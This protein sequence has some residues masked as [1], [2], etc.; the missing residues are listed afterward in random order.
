MGVIGFGIAVVI[1]LSGRVLYG[2]NNERIIKR[3]ILHLLQP[4]SEEEEF[5]VFRGDVW[6]KISDQ[7][8]LG[9][10]AFHWIFHPEN[11]V[12]GPS[13]THLR[14]VVWWGFAAKDL[15]TRCLQVDPSKRITV[16]EALDHPWIVVSG[17]H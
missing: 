12:G 17:W 4:E 3:K 13:V 11:C 16:E 2:S 14:C 7:G 15:I 5:P 6:S 8:L 10:V 9:S 1:S